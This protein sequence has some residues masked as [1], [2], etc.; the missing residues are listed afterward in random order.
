MAV[1]VQDHPGTRPSCWWRFSAPA[2]RERVGGTGDP[3]FEHLAYVPRYRLG[4]PVDWMDRWAAE[5]YEKGIAFDPSEPPRF[6]AQATY[7]QR[8]GLLLPGERRRL[9]PAD[10]EP[11]RLVDPGPP[12]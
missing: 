4:I 3:A 12:G 8:L 2:H 9:T 1:W 10:F 6:E 7:L 11:E 5:Y